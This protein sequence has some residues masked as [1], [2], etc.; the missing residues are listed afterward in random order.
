MP[1][2]LVDL[3]WVDFDLAVPPSGPAAQPLL[4]NSN[5]PR[6]KWADSGTL[7]IKVNPGAGA[8]ADG[9]PYISLI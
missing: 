9:T 2:L 6:Q 3:G 8:R 1:H 7:K 5:Q 4:P